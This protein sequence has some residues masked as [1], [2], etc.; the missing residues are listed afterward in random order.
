MR[1]VEFLGS[2]PA[3]ALLEHFHRE[4]L[5]VDMGGASTYEYDYEKDGTKGV[6]F[7]VPEPLAIMLGMEDSDGS[8]DVVEAV[9]RVCDAGTQCEKADDD[10]SLLPDSDAGVDVADSQSPQHRTCATQTRCSG[11]TWRDRKSPVAH[12]SELFVTCHSDSDISETDITEGYFTADE[13]E[14][15]EEHIAWVSEQLW[16]GA[17]ENAVAVF[18]VGFQKFFITQSP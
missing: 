9:G 3:K 15:E 4:C 7:P 8:D 2:N 10:F 18:N 12:L 6:L 14:F 5:L 11:E 17:P 16:H 1:Q 13:E